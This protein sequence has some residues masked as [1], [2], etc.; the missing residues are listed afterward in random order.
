[1][2][3][4][5]GARHLVGA[6]CLLGRL[7]RLGFL[8][9][10]L[11]RPV[12][13]GYLTGIALIMIAGQLENVTGVPVEG[14]AFLADTASFAGHIELVH[15]PTLGMS[16]TVLRSCSFVVGALLPR[17]PGPLVAV[18]MAAAVSALF[19]LDRVGMRV[20]G[21][22]PR[23][24][25]CPQFR[26]SRSATSRFC[27]RRHSATVPAWSSTA[28]TRR[29]ASPTRRTSGIGRWPSSTSSPQHAGCC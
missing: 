15:G 24:C 29:S 11:S 7:A 9:D 2:P 26:P 14:G 27:S 1:M 21:R 13:V 16:T 4:R 6:I 12:L 5:R 8:A 23:D 28:T 22:S 17:V 18:L 10:M 3:H 20:V 25:R 19:A